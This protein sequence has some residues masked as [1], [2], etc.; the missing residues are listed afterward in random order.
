[1]KLTLISILIFAPTIVFSQTDS[2]F[3]YKKR[4]LESAEIQFL[5]SYYEQDG[6][7]AAVTG[8]IGN[9]ELEDFTS[10]I[11]VQI[12]LNEDDILTVSTGISAYSSASSSNVNPFYKSGASNSA[13]SQLKGSP[14][15]ASSGASKKD[16]WSN[17]SFAY[18]HHTNDRNK[19]YSTHISFANEYDYSS[20]GFGGTYTELF[21]QKN[22]EI[23]LKANIFFDQWRPVYPTELKTYKEVDGDLSSG[24]F[25]N[26]DIYNHNGNSVDKEDVNWL[27]NQFSLIDNKRRNTYSLSLFL[28]QILNTRTQ[29]ALMI[30]CIAQTGLLSNPM[31]RIYFADKDDFY[32][33]NAISIPLYTSPKNTDVFM[34]ADDIERLP[35]LRIKVPI[36]IRFHHFFNEHIILRSYYRYYWDNWDINAHT[37]RFELPIKILKY[38]TLYPAYRYH[39]QSATRYFATFNNA[40]STD[41]YYTSDYDLGSFHSHQYSL[42]LKYTDI[43]TKLKLLSIGLKNIELKYDN[44]KRSTQLYAHLLSISLT[45][46]TN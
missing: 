12:P 10:D 17:A 4:V 5:S 9:E 28:S 37:L 15:I 11:V 31:Q 40:L 46:T 20:L 13:T 22:T 7:N 1:M 38:F 19:I 39:T 45:L 25:A 36:G 6:N 18:T 21:N 43:F 16:T 14:W 27:P 26:E 34:L 41:K 33:G 42:A 32:M 2:T 23:N 35:S 3:H 29:A 24:F 30:D 44:Y 8:G